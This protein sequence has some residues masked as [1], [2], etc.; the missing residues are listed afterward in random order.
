ME[1]AGRR[2]GR[3]AAGRR[4]GMRRRPAPGLAASLLPVPG[5]VTAA[6]APGTAVAPPAAAANFIRP[7]A[8]PRGAAAPS[9]RRR[10]PPGAA[11]PGSCPVPHRHLGAARSPPAL[12]RDPSNCGCAPCAVRLAAH[13]NVHASASISRHFSG[14]FLGE[15]YLTHRPAAVAHTCFFLVPPAYAGSHTRS[16]R[17]HCSGPSQEPLSRRAVGHSPTGRG[18]LLRASFLPIQCGSDG[19]HL[20][21]CT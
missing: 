9:R 13:A 16:A 18:F 8:R 21:P 15:V 11:R 20:H 5:L 2:R 6:D 14:G 7:A 4:R 19:F 17:H 12:R 1:R 3:G 10:A